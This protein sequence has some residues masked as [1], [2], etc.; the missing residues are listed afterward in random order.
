MGGAWERMV[1][2]V[3]K[4]L[5]P[6]LCEFGDRIEDESFRTLMCEVEEIINS[7]PLTTP[8]SDPRDLTPLSPNHLLKMKSNVYV[9]PPGQFQ[10]DDMYMRQRW[11]R[12]QYLANVFWTRWKKE[13]LLSLQERQKWNTPQ[14]N[15]MINDI[16]LVKDDNLHRSCWS[17]GRVISVE[18]DKD[19]FV[20]SVQIKTL[21]SE[22][23]R[24]VTKLVL[25][26]PSEK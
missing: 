22:L 21:N 1:R 8:S 18:A 13:Y 3:R 12:I 24:P 19:G 6:M 9:A 16:V 5:A 14:R 26:V 17:M 2:S 10:R 23:R 15:L 11:R 20:R 7:R 25:L 4:V